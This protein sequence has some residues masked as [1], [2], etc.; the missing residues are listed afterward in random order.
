M[1]LIISLFGIAI[2]VL[3]AIGLVRPSELI[4]FVEVFWKSPKGL[5]T[6]VALRIVLGVIMLAVA[7]SSRFPVAFRVLGVLSLVSAGLV[8]VIGLDRV[9]SLIQWWASRP[10]GFVRAWSLAAAAFGAFL[11]YGAS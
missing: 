6:A 2:I 1:A 7:S 10:A 8:P 5:Y 4:R 3:G 9:R 11:V